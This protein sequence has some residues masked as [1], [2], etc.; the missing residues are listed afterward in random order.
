M[1]MEYFNSERGF[2][3]TD[4][5]G[6][7]NFH[8]YFPD[9]VLFDKNAVDFDNR[10]IEKVSGMKEHINTIWQREIFDARD[11]D[12]HE[13]ENLRN[14]ACARPLMSQSPW[15]LKACNGCKPCHGKVFTLA[16]KAGLS[17]GKGYNKGFLGKCRHSGKGAE[18]THFEAGFEGKGYFN[19]FYDCFTPFGKGF[20]RPSQ[21]QGFQ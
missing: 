15:R 5:A 1:T 4:H 7:E 8:P 19:R 17:Y 16:P 14:G 6:C 10:A 11:D 13:N 9:R 12:L 18:K 20:W 21:T 3:F 2:G